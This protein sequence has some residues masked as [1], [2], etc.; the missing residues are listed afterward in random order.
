MLFVFFDPDCEHCQRAVKHMDEECADF[1]G[2]AIYFVSMQAW[3][4]IDRFA[5][6]YAPHL[7]AQHNVV[8][9]QDPGAGYML[10][11]HPLRFPSLFLYSSEHKLLDYEDNEETVFRIKR[12]MAA[13]AK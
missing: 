8:F 4:K 5:A 7:R 9:L 1:R 2:A 12:A 10:G 3:E 11:F 6:G 13:F